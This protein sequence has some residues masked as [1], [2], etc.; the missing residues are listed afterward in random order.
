M[1]ETEV[2]SSWRRPRRQ[3]DAVI[4]RPSGST[5]TI[6]G[7][8]AAICLVGGLTTDGFA[9]GDNAKSILQASAFVGIIALGMTVIMISGNVFSLSLGTT[10]AVAAM[11]FL[12]SLRFGVTAAIILTI[13][14]GVAICAVQGV[15]IGG[16]EANPIIVTIAAGVIQVGAALYVTGGVTVNPPVESSYG[17]L[18]GR[19]AGV[20]IGFL[21]FVGLTVILDG[22]LRGTR[23]GREV[24][25]TGENKKAARAAAFNTGRLTAGAFALAGAAAAVSGILLGAFNQNATLSIQGTLTFD[26]IAAALV[27]GTAIAGGRGSAARTLF[28]AIVI[29]T[30]SSLLLLQGYSTGVQILVRGAIVLLVVVLLHLGMR[31][32]TR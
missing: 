10:A 6:I 5:L 23:F 20:P 14:L 9:T 25:A 17:F 22:I 27:G 21:V 12:Y 28:G 1:S 3:A 2:F 4:P 13:L 11:A 16:L 7:T 26:A 32:A 31:Q 19:A 15:I 8:F 30:I 24:Y 29:A 18:S